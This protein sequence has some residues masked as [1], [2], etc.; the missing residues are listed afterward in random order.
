[1][2]G[3]D[4]RV[5]W[6]GCAGERAGGGG[7]GAG[8]RMGG[9]ISRSGAKSAKDQARPAAGGGPGG[10]AR[11]GRGAADAAAME[12]RPQQAASEQTSSPA[13]RRPSNRP[14][15]LQQTG[16]RAGGAGEIP[17][18]MSP[19]A[20]KAAEDGQRIADSPSVQN[21]T[22][23]LLQLQAE[24]S[25]GDHG[26]EQLESVEENE[27]TEAETSLATLEEEFSSTMSLSS[28]EIRIIGS[29]HRWQRGNLLGSGSYGKVYMAMNSDSGEIFVV[30]Q[31]P[32]NGA[33]SDESSEEVAQLEMEIALLGTLNHPNIVKYLG[34]E[35]NNVSN[36]LSIFLEH[37]PGG[38]IAELVSRFGKLDESVIRKYT[39]E[40]LEGLIY[41]HDKGIIHRD[42]KGQNILVDNHG[43]CKLADF[44]ASRH[45]QSAE[46]AQNMSFK[47]TPVFM[48]P[49]VILEQ[50]YSKKSDI[51]S[52]G[53]TVLQMATVSVSL[54][55]SLSPSVSYG[56]C[57]SLSPSVSYGLCL[58]LSPSVSY[59]LCL[60]LFPS[61]SY[62]LSLSLCPS[63]SYGL[64]LSLSPP[65]SYG[66]CLSLCPSVSYGLCLSLSPS[67]SYG[68]CLSLSPSVSYGLCLSLSLPVSRCV[69][70]SLSFSLLPPPAPT[71]N[72]NHI[73]RRYAQTTSRLTKRLY[74]K[75]AHSTL[76]PY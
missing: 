54:C 59:G 26:F 18:F 46:S 48:S 39:R 44:G 11:G 13:Q 37:M 53:C 30:K 66:L 75:P 28:A 36:E 72:P 35:R 73:E 56:L 21:F 38:S 27:E 20:A 22:S 24:E 60:S 40:V 70:L 12:A 2:E 9:F 34:T 52:V 76:H 51:W 65:V 3:E 64:C 50:R 41:L 19:L 29:V 5:G 63:V 69:S 31:V 74:G 7:C 68:L 58:S 49:E 42:I 1:V 10:G 33:N 55:L 57:L 15:S 71:L 6:K 61:V 43:V 62:G 25:Q 23:Q 32:F 17:E 8:A 14:P 47:G 45:M 16:G 4:R 67:V